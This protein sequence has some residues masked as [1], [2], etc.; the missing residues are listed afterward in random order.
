MMKENSDEKTKNI[1]HSTITDNE[2][3]VD[4]DKVK[5]L[6]QHMYIAK[7]STLPEIMSKLKYLGYND[8]REL[9]MNKKESWSKIY[10]AVAEVLMSIGKEK[11]AGEVLLQIGLENKLSPS[12]RYVKQKKESCHSMIDS[13]MERTKEKI[14]KENIIDIYIF[15][16][17]PYILS[18]PLLSD[19]MHK[20]N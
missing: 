9:N 17:K 6:V 7:N 18:M 16:I 15:K 14:H 11:E 19:Q 10:L 4:E 12:E 8:I 1:I 20:S 5:L 13:W 2:G 3:R